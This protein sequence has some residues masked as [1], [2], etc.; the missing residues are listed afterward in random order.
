[1]DAAD[2]FDLVFAVNQGADTYWSGLRS[3]FASDSQVFFVARHLQSLPWLPQLKAMRVGKDAAASIR[4]F[5]VGELA[6][7]TV[8][9][10]IAK[11]RA[12]FDEA[13][14]IIVYLPAGDDDALAFLL[15]VL[16]ASQSP[17]VLVL[18]DSGRNLPLEARARQNVVCVAM[19]SGQGSAEFE[20]AVRGFLQD[21]WESTVLEHRVELA[22]AA[23][24]GDAERRRRDA[25]AIV[26]A[27][28]DR[29]NL[30]L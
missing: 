25:R 16:G 6:T 21:R 30:L 3:R 19:R 20:T 22:M 14:G 26:E 28:H 1:M 27:Y 18:F 8:S 13:K 12:L 17:P 9:V 4:T 15:G 7:C 5:D 29:Q 24:H 11:R 2:L 23:R 10:A